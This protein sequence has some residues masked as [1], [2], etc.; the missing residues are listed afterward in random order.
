MSLIRSFYRL[1]QF[2]FI[3]FLSAFISL[4]SFSPAQAQAAQDVNQEMV[5]KGRALFQQNCKTC[6]SV[7]SVVVGPALKDVHKRRRLDWIINFVHNPQKVIDAGDPVAVDLFKQYKTVMT[8]FPTLADEEIASIVEFI[9]AESMV[10]PV[11]AQQTVVDGVSPAPASDG[12]SVIVLSLIVVVLILVLIMLVVFLTVVKR[13]LK[14]KEEK[15]V[16]EDKALVNQKFEVGKALKSGMF[17]TI[18]VVVFLAVGMRQCWLELNTIGIEQGYA[19]VQPIPF[20][21]KL[22]AGDYKIDCNYCHTGVTKGKQANIPSTN[23]C[24]NCHAHIRTGPKFGDAAI[25]KVVEAHEQNRPIRWVRVHNL[26]DFVYFNHSQHVN[27]AGL[28][29]QTCHG[30]IQEMEVVRQHSPLNMGWCI[31]CHRETSI[32]KAD[33]AYYDKLI[34]VHYKGAKE[35]KVAEVGGLEC[36]KCHY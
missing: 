33:N 19:P 6:H 23:I 2:S 12:L 3:L 34:E 10:E 14:D 22:H 1:P 13:Y 8:A 29:C 15:L 25:S 5:D 32:N 11:A 36:S 9:K 26:P 30:P 27:V 24:M 4:S 16:E 20:S 21:H 28:E 35:V 7:H 31:S 18:V 17:I